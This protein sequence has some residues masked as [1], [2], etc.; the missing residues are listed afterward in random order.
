MASEPDFCDDDDEFYNALIPEAR[1][2][3]NV[4]PT[5][6]QPGSRGS[7]VKTGVKANSGD[8]PI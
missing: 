1:H 2:S 4:T 5:A 7:L 3:V 8:P 6:A